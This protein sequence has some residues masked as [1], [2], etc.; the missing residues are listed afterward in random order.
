MRW[1]PLCWGCMGEGPSTG[2]LPERDSLAL[3]P[4]NSEHVL[5][6]G[7]QG[8]ARSNRPCPGQAGPK[9]PDSSPKLV[10]VL[11][12]PRASGRS[13]SISPGQSHPMPVVLSNHQQHILPRAKLSYIWEDRRCS[14]PALWRLPDLPSEAVSAFGPRD[15]E[16]NSL[17]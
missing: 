16:F 4:A 5:V 3:T 17:A 14:R 8:R 6:L 7:P 9:Q 15:H 13:W 11:T 10:C 2:G 12:D 1:A